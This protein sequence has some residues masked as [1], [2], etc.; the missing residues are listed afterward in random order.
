MVTSTLHWG[1]VTRAGDMVQVGGDSVRR[2]D[3]LRFSGAER[4]VAV[5]ALGRVLYPVAA[6]VSAGFPVL[7]PRLG[8]P[9]F[10]FVKG[11]EQGR[12]RGKCKRKEC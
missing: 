6:S 8:E 9:G 2:V 1:H 4:S 12:N 7:L 3:V 11:K 5:S 10:F